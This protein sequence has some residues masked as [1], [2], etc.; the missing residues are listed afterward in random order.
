MEKYNKRRGQFQRHAAWHWYFFHW[1]TTAARIVIYLFIYYVLIVIYFAILDSFPTGLCRLWPNAGTA[2]QTWDW[3][4]SWVFYCEANQSWLRGWI[5]QTWQSCLTLL[6]NAGGC[7]VVSCCSSW[8]IG[9]DSQSYCE[10]PCRVRRDRPIGFNF[11][12]TPEN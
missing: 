1:T 6:S 8:L 11:G 5:M 2:L 4:A 12:P 9:G 10:G 7:A 3:F